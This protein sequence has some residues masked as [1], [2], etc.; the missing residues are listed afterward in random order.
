LN[1]AYFNA[2][3]SVGK[4]L[5]GSVDYITSRN[6][7]IQGMGFNGG[8]AA[9]SPFATPTAAYAFGTT[10]STIVGYDQSAGFCALK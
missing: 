8:L 3:Q 10:T 2:G 6:G 7:E 5:Q 9:K 4:G 1:G